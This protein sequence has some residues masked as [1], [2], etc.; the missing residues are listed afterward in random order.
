MQL[1]EYL[2]KYTSAK[3]YHKTQTFDKDAAKKIYTWDG[4][5]LH[6]KTSWNIFN[7]HGL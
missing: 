7:L 5:I 4:P 2:L 1:I 6:Q 3:N